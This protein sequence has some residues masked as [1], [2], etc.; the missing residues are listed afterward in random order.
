MYTKTPQGRLCQIEFMALCD[1]PVGSTDFMALCKETD[2]LII[3]HVPE[4]SLDRRDHLRRFILLVDELYN[5][6]VRVYI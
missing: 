1:K 2:I 6:K 3:R 4:L 5:H